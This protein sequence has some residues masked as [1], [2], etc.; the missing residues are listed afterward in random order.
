MLFNS[1]VYLLAFLPAALLIYSIADRFPA[2]RTWTLIGLSLVF[3]SYWDIRF[4]PL[5]V[6]SILINW[7]S[8]QLFVRTKWPAIVTGTIAANLFVLGIFKYTNFF[9]GSFAAIFG[10]SLGRFELA[11]PLGIS[12]FT[13][14]HIMYFV[15]LR[16]GVAPTLTLDR[17]ALYICFFPQ[18]LS[19]P[20]VRWHEIIWQF[21]KAAFAPG[22]EGR[23]A[24]G[25]TLIVIGL[26]Q[27]VFLGDTLGDEV[28]LFYQ[29][30]KI[31]DIGQFESWIAVLSFTFQIYFDFNGYTDVALGTALLFGIQLPQNFNGPYRATSLREFWRRWHMTLS[32]FLRDYLYIPLGG[33]RHGLVRQ[34]I[35]LM[36][37]MSLG[38][39]WHGAGWLFIIWGTLHGV[40]LTVDLLWRRFGLQMPPLAGWIATFAFVT[41]TWI[42]FRAPSLNMAARLFKALIVGGPSTSYNGTQTLVLAAVCA[43]L[44]PPSY[45]ICRK[46]TERPSWAVAIALSVLS[47]AILVALGKEGNYEFIYFQF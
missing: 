3:Y 31:F 7:L 8:S 24:L 10:T 37:T 5:M 34:I 11:L 29:Q 46:L 12:F 38:G 33:N 19:G 42:F 35:A 27:K 21:G 17:Y 4:L 45:V 28:N 32:R 6:G 23:F 41:L 9:A 1:Y 39:L 26:T 22:W 43:I 20:L 30:A 25:L 36:L 2:A 18:V 16:R 14:H 15:D 44:F 47:A 13:F 40:G